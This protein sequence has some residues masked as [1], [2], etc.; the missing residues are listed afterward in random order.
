MLPS[1]KMPMSCKSF[2][3]SI[4]LRGRINRGV[5]KAVGL[6]SKRSALQ[7]GRLAVT[8]VAAGG[9]QRAGWEKAPGSLETQGELQSDRNKRKAPGLQP[10]RYRGFLVLVF[11]FVMGWPWRVNAQE[12][13]LE[14]CDALPVITVT[15]AG[16]S[17]T[18]LVDTA[19]TSMLN[20][21]SFAEG[22]SKDVRVTSWHGTLA[23]S[24]KEVTLEEFVVGR[25]KLVGLKLPAIDLS[26][27][28][29]ACGR[30][31]DGVLG[32]DLIAKLGITI[33]LK[34][35]TLHVR[36]VDEERGAELVAE[37]QGG[38]HACLEAFNASDEAAF[39]ECFDRKIVL[40]TLNNELYGR[41]QV[42]GYFRD[43]Y[44]NQSPAAKIEMRE[45]AF[46]PVGDAVWYEYEFTIES[47]RGVLSGRGMAM[48]KKSEGRWRTASMHHTVE[49]L[50]P[51]VAVR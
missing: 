9:S 37:M 10:G 14:K 38:M 3:G 5:E 29:E 27:I 47:T 41:E 35:E 40:F 34:R 13:A 28:G 44:F 33:D 36:T 39:G 12:I 25:T 49:K 45:S 21:K 19:A 7:V 46:H 6:R 11:V 24:A 42:V 23:T 22:K 26:A 1:K 16:Q 8:F 50:E 15:V 30:R 20:L 17:T 2:D 31:I 43:K 32:V 18:F 51:A 48:C 4:R